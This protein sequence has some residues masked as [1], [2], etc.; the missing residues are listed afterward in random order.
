MASSSSDC[1]RPVF[2]TNIP[3]SDRVKDFIASFYA[4]S[5]DPSRNEE[6][7]EYFAAD[8]VLVMGDKTAKGTEQIRRLREGM[9]EKVKSRRHRLEKV[10]PASFGPGRKGEEHEYMICGSADFVMK[11]GEDDVASATWAGRAVLTDVDG[12]RLKYA[13]YQV[14]IHSVPTEQAALSSRPR[15]EVLGRPHRPLFDTPLNAI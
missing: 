8:A 2:P 13:F 11:S 14:Y 5:D 10:F 9:W 7:V 4:A 3:V 6:W 15:A 1:Y 12:G